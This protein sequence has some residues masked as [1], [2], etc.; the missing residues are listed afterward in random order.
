MSQ[1]IGKTLYDI[2]KKRRGFFSIGELKTKN[3]AKRR[4]SLGA[5][6]CIIPK[7]I[8]G[9][10]SCWDSFLDAHTHLTGAA[11]LGAAFG[12]GMAFGAAAGLIPIFGVS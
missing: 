7:N 12:D 4:R 10:C 8:Q 9:E 2:N 1:S 11:F 5:E 6:S 3:D